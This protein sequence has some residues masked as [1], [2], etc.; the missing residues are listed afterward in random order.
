MSTKDLVVTM[1]NNMW[2][3]KTRKLLEELV[4]NDDVDNKGFYVQLYYNLKKE[5]AQEIFLC[6]SEE[7][8]DQH[9]RQKIQRR[10]NKM[11][12]AGFHK[13]ELLD[14]CKDEKNV[15][16]LDNIVDEYWKS[17]KNRETMWFAFYMF[18]ILGPIFWGLMNIMQ[19]I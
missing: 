4:T 3:R 16:N 18:L 19:I 9:C 2:Y 17:F 10:V 15:N 1:S 12:R 14:F 11:V 8:K 6:A 5:N 7:F 13:Q